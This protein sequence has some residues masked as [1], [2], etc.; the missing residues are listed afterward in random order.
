MMVGRTAFSTPNL[1]GGQAAKAGISCASCHRNGRGN[2]HFLFPGLSGAAG[3]ADVTTS[4][5]SQI[6]GDRTDNPKRIPDLAKDSHAIPRSG[7]RAALKAFVRGLIV[8][9]FDGPVPDP[10]VLTGLAA[11]V[12]ALDGAKCPTADYVLADDRAALSEAADASETAAAQMAVRGSADVVRLM[13]G[14]TRS[15]LGR[16]HDRSFSLA[17]RRKI[18]RLDRA[19]VPII[20]LAIRD[21][22]KGIGA[23][24]LWQRDLARLRVGRGDTPAQRGPSPSA[25]PH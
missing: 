7:D 5:F 20:D 3:T 1:L 8:E 19:L 21:P 24:R 6:R 4:L 17:G 2:P 23:V 22:A 13:L 12:A 18:E 10:A 11:Y 9:E 16:A 14:S 15:A 25:L